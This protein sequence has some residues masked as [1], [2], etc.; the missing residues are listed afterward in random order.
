[1]SELYQ[2]YLGISRIMLPVLAMLCAFL[3]CRLYIGT[4]KK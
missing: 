3:W 2:I 4:R 1:M